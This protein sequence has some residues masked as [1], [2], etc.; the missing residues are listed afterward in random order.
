MRICILDAW[1][2]EDPALVNSHW[3]A[4]RTIDVLKTAHPGACVAVLS[5]GD[6]GPSTVDA[7]FT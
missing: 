1:H 5:G 7:A 6:L 2:P 3:V 4:E